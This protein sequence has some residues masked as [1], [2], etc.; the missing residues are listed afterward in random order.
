[1]LSTSTFF[2]AMIAL[3][4]LS[5]SSSTAAH[6][7]HA[8]RRD[9]PETSD[10]AI[11]ILGLQSTETATGTSF[12]VPKGC[13]EIPETDAI[14]M[15]S[16]DGIPSTNRVEATLYGSLDDCLNG[17]EDV[18]SVTSLD[19]IVSVGDERI[20]VKAVKVEVGVVQERIN[21][22]RAVA[23]RGVIS[24]PTVV[25]NEVA[26][27]GKFI[28][29]TPPSNKV[30]HNQPQTHDSSV[31]QN[32]H[33]E[34]ASSQPTRQGCQPVS[35]NANRALIEPIPPRYSNATVWL[36]LSIEDCMARRNRVRKLTQPEGLANILP[37]GEPVVIRAAFVIALPTPRRVRMDGVGNRVVLTEENAVAE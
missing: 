4:P 26:L 36:Y 37:S 34:I 6:A 11:A 16:I 18:G 21:E 33:E 17:V 7:A 30:K 2:L 31:L 27:L 10:Q 22:R 25:D 12:P 14:D 28:P 19:G 24:L 23:E 32:Q 5:L 15:I 35:L 29:T 9:L 20:S 8:F 1:M 13:S 3:N